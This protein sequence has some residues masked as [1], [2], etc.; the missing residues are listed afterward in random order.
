M[1]LKNSDN[2]LKLFLASIIIGIGPKIFGYPIVDEY[3]V[4]ML[5]IGLLLRKIIIITTVTERIEKKIYNLHEKAF[6][7]LTIYFLFQSFRGGLWLNDP[8][9]LRWVIFFLIVI[10]IFFVF[11]NYQIPNDPNYVAKTVIYSITIY[12]LFYFLPFSLKSFALSKFVQSN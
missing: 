5:L 7:L 10:F 11:R 9:M 8:R 12:F 2:F 1:V 3:W 4:L 6:I